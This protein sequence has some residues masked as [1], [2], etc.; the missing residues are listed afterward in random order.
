MSHSG[1]CTS[2]CV[3]G[4]VGL[5]AAFETLSVLSDLAILPKRLLTVWLEQK[6]SL[7]CCAPTNSVLRL[8]SLAVLFLFATVG[9][10]L[11]MAQAVWVARAL[12]FKRMSDRMSVASQCQALLFLLIIWRKRP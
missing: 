2:S 9:K 6:F 4:F 12:C 11:L 1:R 5:S 8:D 10:R 3:K 7:E